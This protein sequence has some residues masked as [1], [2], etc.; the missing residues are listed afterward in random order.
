MPFAQYVAA[1]REIVDDPA[2]TTRSLRSQIGL[3]SKP[4]RGIDGNYYFFRL[5]DAQPSHAPESLDQVRDQ[6]AEDA[7]TITAFENLE[8]RAADYRQRVIDDGL[9]AVAESAGTSVTP[10][11]PF[12][13]VGDDAGNPPQVSG[14]GT[15]QAFVD[16]AFA[17]VDKLEDPTGDLGQ[18]P[19]DPRVA[20]V[21]LYQSA[22]GPA[23][24][25]FVLESYEPATRSRFAQVVP[26]A[27]YRAD[28]GLNRSLDIAPLSL[29]GI[30]ERVGFDL[31]AYEEDR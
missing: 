24:A 19:L 16:A 17:L 4:L 6:V 13:K 22:R 14:V 7:R 26:E 20:A 11:G 28:A 15:S 25:L 2:A 12:R 9:D 23:L 21:P 30:A 31:A 3:T 10:T 18:L 1:S 27:R 5:L 8:A 29:E